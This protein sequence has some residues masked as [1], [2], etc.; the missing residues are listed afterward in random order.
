M[1]FAMLALFIGFTSSVLTT[2]DRPV[3]SQYQHSRTRSDV[4][5]SLHLI[6]ESMEQSAVRGMFEQ[7][8]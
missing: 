5:S 8:L 6:L 2:R 7:L 1:S 3:R 4:W